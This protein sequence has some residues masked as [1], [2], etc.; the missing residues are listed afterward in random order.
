[1]ALTYQ[2]VYYPL[3]VPSRLDRW[4][5]REFPGVTQGMIEKAI[6]K[7][8][9]R[10]NGE[11]GRASTQLANHDKIGIEIHLFATFVQARNAA[12][13]SVVPAPCEDLSRYILD[14]TNDFLIFNKPSG[15]D[16]QGG[17][18]VR[19]S[20]DHWLRAQSREYRL[21]HRLDRDT[22]GILI[23]A[24]NLPTAMFLTQL[25]RERQVKKVYRA[26]VHGTPNPPEGTITAP[27]APDP[28]QRARMLV[29]DGGLPASTNYRT[30]RTLDHGAEVEL[31]PSTGRKHQLR[32]HLMHIGCP[33][34]G[35][36]KYN[37]QFSTPSGR[38]SS[39]LFLHSYRLLF[40]DKNGKPQEWIAPLPDYWPA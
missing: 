27:L 9:I 40:T 18:E 6:R 34:L 16:V 10:V 30:L 23:V 13:V 8:F 37:T 2:F 20:V 5:R 15:L 22:S 35:D 33:I 4:L 26:I 21:V 1:M 11:R 17:R 3:E 19:T 38:K 39:H 28:T 7:R 29:Q 12:E 36:K 14:E 32:V 25:F 24:K 31:F